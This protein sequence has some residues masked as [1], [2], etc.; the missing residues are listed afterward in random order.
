MPVR[1]GED[2]SPAK[3]ESWFLYIRDQGAAVVS[4]SWSAAAR[5]FP[6]S[7]RISDAIRDCARD[8]RA[9]LGTVICFAAG[10]ENRDINDGANNSVNGFAIHPDVIAVA[11]STSMDE[12][13][14]YSNHGA[15]IWICAP[16][17]GAGGRGILT[18]DVRGAVDTP[19]G[20][21]ALG[22][23]SSD[24]TAEFGGTSSSTPLVAGIC[25]LLLS[26]RPQTTAREIK[27]LLKHTARKI[28]P[29]EDYDA[30]QHSRN[31][32]YGCVDALA[33][34]HMIMDF[35]EPA[36][37]IGILPS[38]G[39]EGHHTTNG[40]A[41]AALPPELADLYQPWLDRIVKESM[42]ADHAKN[43]DRT[44]RP[45]HFLNA[46]W[47]GAPPFSNLPED[48]TEAVKKFGE[49]TLLK[50]G[51]LPWTI[52][53]RY[54]ELV[55]AFKAR[56][57]DAILHHSAWLGHYVGDCH[58]PL[59]T[60]LNHDGQLT[61]QKGLH[62][63][64]ESMVLEFIEPQEIQP[65]QGQRLKKPILTMAFEWIRESHGLIPK[66]LAADLELRRGPTRRRDKQAF[67][68]R[69]KP[70][71]IDRLSKGA[72][73]LASAWYSAWFVA[74]RPQIDENSQSRDYQDFSPTTADS[75]PDPES[76][77]STH[78]RQHSSKGSPTEGTGQ[79]TSPLES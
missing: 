24:F 73:R 71:A 72:T 20:R 30:N 4:C 11:A 25:G 33:A 22:Y 78:S 28:G 2:L 50:H 58:V 31:F 6:L 8:G 47:Y 36:P 17:S 54:E 62:S 55:R 60:T 12:K 29:S 21:F 35:E 74:G 23:D 19:R 3:V 1:W 70:L 48:Y 52:S 26:L 5:N 41:V 14:N 45:R 7:T 39:G 18:A 65:I 61:R 44:E 38:W 27:Q 49:A 67:A 59:H 43:T 56:N 53:K 15:E 63:Y 37:A 40:K 79:K 64:F 77:S 10:N 57:L 9:G 69:M 68:A 76:V 66:I 34:S 51:V 16:S 13:A 32:G 42:A 75:M 46:D